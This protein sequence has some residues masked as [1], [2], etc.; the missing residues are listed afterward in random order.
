MIFDKENL[1]SDKQAITVTAVSENVI[2]FGADHAYVVQP[3]EKGM[4]HNL[5][6][7]TEDFVGLTSLKVTLQTSVDEAFSSPIT[8]VESGAVL[9]ADLKAGYKFPLTCLPEGLKQYVRLNYTVAGTASAGNVMAGLVLD[10]QT[11]V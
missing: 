7:V 10:K 6:Q 9:A 1:Y 4:I 11:N 2:D 8:V 3:N 5:V